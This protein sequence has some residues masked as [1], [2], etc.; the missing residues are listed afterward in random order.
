MELFKKK[1]LIIENGLLLV[2]EYAN[3]I[4]RLH[5]SLFCSR[6]VLKASLVQKIGSAIKEV[7]RNKG[8]T[9]WYTPHMAAASHA[10][11]KR[12]PLVD[13]LLEIRDARIPL[14][15][16]CELIKHHSPSSRSII[17]LNKTDLANHIQLKE[18]LKY[19]EQQKCLVFGVNSHN[20]DNIKE[21]LLQICNLPIAP[22][23]SEHTL[24][25]MY[26]V[27]VLDDLQLLNFLR[28]RV[29]EL[30][31]I[32]HGDQTITLML[33]GIPNV[34]KSALANSL[35]QIGRISAAEKGRL[36]HAIVSPHPGETKSISGLKIASHPSIYV[37]DTP[38]VFPAEILDAEACSNLA[39]TGAIRDCL[40]GEVELAEYFL[41][42]FNSCDEYKKWAKLSL[43]GADDVSELER[44]Q[45][46]QY[47]TD[48][49][50]DFVVNKVRRT[51][52]EAV[53]SFDGN[54]QDE[55]IMLQLIKAE[56]AVLGDAFNLPPDSDD[57]VRK[58]AAKL[59]NLYRTGR[60]GHYTL[61][62]APCNNLES[63][64]RSSLSCG[65]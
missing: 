8:S 5:S 35:H 62:L 37:L 47:L 15:S 60:L 48:H 64:R 1:K 53:S 11:T 7:V 55:E 50:Q 56:F 45:K 65:V 41:S 27:R 2:R 51:L 17:I 42:I 24:P 25:L 59:L 16:T 58:V 61:D 57:Y 44:R 30:P 36:K 43:S 28:A 10:I 4:M 6:M 52:F 54:L 40:V 29:R 63:L 20:K 12:I 46:R 21:F 39:L 23:N 9:W 18:W 31:K 26:C 49:T 14:S 33:V 32:G 34:G 13:I 19:F 3:P 38:G 22:H